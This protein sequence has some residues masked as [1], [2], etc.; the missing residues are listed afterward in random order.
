MSFKLNAYVLNLKKGGGSWALDDLKSIGVWEGSELISGLCP[1]GALTDIVTQ[2]ENTTKAYPNKQKPLTFTWE[3]PKEDKML[4]HTST[5]K[6]GTFHL[7]AGVIKELKDNRFNMWTLTFD[8][9]KLTNTSKKG[10]I[11]RVNLSY[12]NFRFEPYAGN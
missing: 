5:L 4:F 11:E 3:P 2:F 9:V 7:R 8:E 1:D 10:K 6:N 12:K